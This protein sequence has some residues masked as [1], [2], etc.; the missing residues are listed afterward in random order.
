M[1]LWRYGV[2]DILIIAIIIE[3]YLLHNNLMSSKSIT[4]SDLGTEHLSHGADNMSFRSAT[5]L[6]YVAEFKLLRHKVF[7]IFRRSVIEIS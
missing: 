3:V 5:K 1:G 7:K 2:D 6:C 4:L